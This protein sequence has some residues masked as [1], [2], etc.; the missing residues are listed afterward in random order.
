MSVPPNSPVLPATFALKSLQLEDVYISGL[1]LP[2]FLAHSTSSLVDIWLNLP[3]DGDGVGARLRFSRLVAQQAPILQHL[4]LRTNE[5][6]GLD[7]I[8]PLTPSFPSLLDLTLNSRGVTNPWGRDSHLLPLSITSLL[9]PLL[10]TLALGNAFEEDDEPF[11]KSLQS[12][13]E[14][15]TLP[16]SS[17]LS[18]T[19]AGRMPAMSARMEKVVEVGKKAGVKVQLGYPVNPVR[20][21]F[22]R[23][24]I[25]TEELLRERRSWP[26]EIGTA[27]HAT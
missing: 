11:V 6:Q 12:F 17:V 1:D 18:W 16:P 19:R 5:G 3:R 25:G 8:L 15:R 24:W 22:G 20:R 13:L 27:E 21:S 2:L 7:T 23:G 4:F 10:Q 26:S 14:G 9:A